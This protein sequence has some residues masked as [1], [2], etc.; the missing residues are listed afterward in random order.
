MKMDPDYGTLS[1]V[2][3]GNFDAGGQPTPEQRSS[4]TKILNWIKGEYAVP[5]DNI[6]YHKEVKSKVIEASGLTLD[7]KETVCPGQAFPS[8]QE[9]TRPLKPDTYEAKQKSILLEKFT[10]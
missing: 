2:L 9:I 8:K 6:L 5:T 1:V 3:C 10:Q 4:L 7:G